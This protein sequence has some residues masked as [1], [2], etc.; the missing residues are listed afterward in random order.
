[1]LTLKI[2]CVIIKKNKGRVMLMED[3]NI[4]DLLFDTQKEYTRSNKFK[5][6]IIILL[7]VLMFLEA[8]VGYCGF[9]YYE[10]QFDYVEHMIQQR[11]WI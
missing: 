1:M 8:V 7:I 10:S 5:D 9:V 6:K 4:Q 2:L 3:N 11:T